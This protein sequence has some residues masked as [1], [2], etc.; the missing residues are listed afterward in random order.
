M[1]LISERCLN[2]E[3]VPCKAKGEYLRDKMHDHYDGYPQKNNE[4]ITRLFCQSKNVLNNISLKITKES[5][6]LSRVK[7][8]TTQNVVNDDFITHLSNGG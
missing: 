5:P 8:R 3:H 6:W 7:L 1:L 4:E 2:T